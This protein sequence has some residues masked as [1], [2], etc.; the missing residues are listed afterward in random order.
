MNID[1]KSVVT[2]TLRLCASLLL[3]A[4]SVASAADKPNVILTVSDDSAKGQ[5][6]AVHDTSANPF[7]MPQGGKEVGDPFPSYWDG[8]WHVYTLSAD[9]RQ[10]YHLTSTNLVKWTEHEPAMYGGG[11]ATGTVVR[12]DGKYCLFYTDAGPQTIRLVIS[13]NPWRFDFKKS[14]LVAKADSKI[15]QLH[16]K[17]FRDCYVFFNE[18]EERW[19]MLVEA[20]SDDTVAVGLFKSR[21]LLTWTQHDPIFK[22]KSRKHASCPQVF[23][24]NGRWYLT[25]LDYPTWYYR[26]DDLCGPWRLEGYYHTKRLT[27]GSRWASDGRRQLGWGF[28]TKHNTP[29]GNNRGYGGPL[30]VGREMVL[31][32]DGAIGVRPLPELIAAMRKPSS[33]ADVFACA[34]ELSGKWNVDAERRDFQCTNDAGGVL[35]LDLPKQNPNYYFEAEIE[36]FRP[37]AIAA[38][39]VRCSKE[40]DEGYRVELKPAEKK[41]AIR[42]FA[43]DGGKFDER[44]H[45]FADGAAILLQVF[46]CD[47]QIEAFVDGRASL[48][49]R[50]LKRTEHRVAIEIAAGRATIRKPLLHYFKHADDK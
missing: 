35:L 32:A 17:K 47:G 45:K 7:I 24:R 10:V 33:N 38:V 25:C 30:G 31:T 50:V 40:F 49:T 43:S 36:L 19:W 48:S 20:T 15:Y 27:A 34:K 1:L 37:E 26:A 9:L 13:D 42:H 8:M 29:E 14:R 46:V 12:H 44:E 3:V 6:V 39:V 2:A 5:V 41:I 28:F 21:D 22:D 11:I 18:A 4:C 23:E 16:K